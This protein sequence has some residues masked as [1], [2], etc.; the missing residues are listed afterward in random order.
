MMAYDKV[1]S[2]LNIQVESV[3]AWFFSEYLSE[4]FGVEGFTFHVPSKGSSYREKTR[5]LLA[6]LDGA[7][8]Q[9]DLF[10][11][12]EEIDLIRID[13]VLTQ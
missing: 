8:K 12:H 11:K 6:E 5:D 13:L 10:S 2:E 9:Y 3:Y 7:L 1:L 4:E